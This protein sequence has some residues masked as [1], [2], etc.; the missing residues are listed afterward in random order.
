MIMAQRVFVFACFYLFITGVDLAVGS[1]GGEGTTFKGLFLQFINLAILIYI[2]YR[3]GADKIKGFLKTRRES[4]KKEIDEAQRA[5]EEAENKY[6]EY[7]QRLANIQEKIDSLFK[8]LEEEGKKERDMI[9]SEAVRFSER[10]KEQARLAAQQEAKK[11]MEEVKAEIAELL[12]RRA[13]EAIRKGLK[14]EDQERLVNTFL[15]K[16]S[17]S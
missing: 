1:E 2:I 15:N 7:S 8:E 5:R 16:L 11:V 12:T 10:I 3:F 9:I 6:R 4:I 17:L 13:E 14:D